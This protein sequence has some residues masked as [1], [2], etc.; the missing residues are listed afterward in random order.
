[1]KSALS[2]FATIN[3]EIKFHDGVNESERPYVWLTQEVMYQD[4][5][6]I[7]LPHDMWGALSK[8]ISLLTGAK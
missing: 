7:V 5:A 4:A 8:E 1:M 2:G 3:I 6:T